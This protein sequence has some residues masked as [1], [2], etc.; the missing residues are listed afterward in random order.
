MPPELLVRPRTRPGMP[1]EVLSL[2]EAAGGFQYLGFSVQRLRAGERWEGRADGSEVALVFLGGRARVEFTAGR[3][4]SL[5]GRAHVFASLPHTLYLPL[6]TRFTITAETACEVALCFA[7]AERAFPARLVTP[8]TVEV[9]IRG[10]GNATR[11]IHHLLKPEFPAQR[12]LVV[13]VYAP[14]GNWSSYP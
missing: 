13:E 2:P 4:P 7:R 3:W 12:L 14:G 9:E 6:E 1:Q 5:G 11:R 10:G 8:E